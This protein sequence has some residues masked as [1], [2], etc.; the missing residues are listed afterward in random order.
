M[1]H[2]YISAGLLAAALVFLSW[3][4]Y[5]QAQ[6]KKEHTLEGHIVKIDDDKLTL[7][8]EDKKEI[9][10]TV[11]KEAKITLD[12]KDAKLKDLKPHTK[13]KVTLKEEGDKHTITKIEAG[14]K[15]DK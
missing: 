7:V 13:V 1:T 10:H 9:T 15:K 2:R 8:G 6:D 5:A 11:P 4:A 14:M 12:G 3:G